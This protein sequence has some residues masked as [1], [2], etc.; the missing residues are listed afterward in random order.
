MSDESKYIETTWVDESEVLQEIEIRNMT[1]E[2][3]SKPRTRREMREYWLT[4]ERA[5]EVEAQSLIEEVV[6][7]AIQEPTQP[8]D[9]D[10]DPAVS[11]LFSIIKSDD[12]PDFDSEILNSP[13]GLPEITPVHRT[14]VNSGLWARFGVMAALCAVGIAYI[15]LTMMNMQ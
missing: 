13:E 6:E 8:V 3:P 11:K 5:K 15:V 4:Q 10:V 12:I 7:P 9:Q 14:R 1:T 2:T